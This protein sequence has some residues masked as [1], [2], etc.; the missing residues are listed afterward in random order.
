[1]EHAMVDVQED[2]SLED[3]P[4][5]G[6]R[7]YFRQLED[8]LTLKKIIG[9]YG[10]RSVGKSRFVKTFIHQQM[11]SFAKE[12]Y[13]SLDEVAYSSRPF[14]CQL[15]VVADLY[16][17]KDTHSLYAFMCSTLGV[18]PENDATS[19]NRWKMHIKEVLASNQRRRVFLVFDNAEDVVESNTMFEELM[20]L[21][22]ILVK[23]CRTVKIFITGTTL[24]NFARFGKIYYTL[25]LPPLTE[26]E[27]SQLLD[28]AAPGVQFG[29]EKKTLVDLSEGIPLLILMIG[30]ELT[31][32]SQLI[33]PGEMVE[34]L[35]KF[36]LE[37][38]S[39]DYYPPEQRAAV[40][41]RRF[42]FRL[43]DIYQSQFATLGFI[44]GSFDAHEAKQILGHQTEAVAK[45]ETLIP[46]RRRH[47]L[48]FDSCTGRF[49]IQGVLR[50][51]LKLYFKIRNLPEVRSRYYETFC[52]VM[53]RICTDLGTAEYTRA[54]ALF[55]LEQPN[56][57]KLL[58]EVPNSTQDNYHFF[59]EVVSSCSA[60]IERFMSGLSDHFYSQC[61]LLADRYGQELDKANVHIAMGSSATNSKGNFPDGENH[62]REALKVLKP[63]GPSLS[64]ATI[65]QRLGWN[66]HSQG[67]SDQSLKYLD[68][69]LDISTR[70]GP[71]YQQLLLQTLSSLGIVHTWIGSYEMAK[72][73][74]FEALR[75]RRIH[76]GDNHPF[77]GESL[78]NIGLLF[79]QMG[80]S[81]TA[82]MYF[83]Q[84][85]E[86][87]K[88]N[89]STPWSISFSLNNVANKYCSLNQFDKAL[90]LLDESMN[91]LNAM[92][93][94][95]TG[96]VSLT[97]NS[98]GKVYREMGMYERSAQMFKKAVDMRFEIMPYSI[99]YIWSA[100]QLAKVYAE[101]NKFPLCLWMIREILQ[102]K[103]SALKTMP[104]NDF[105]LE[106]LQMEKDV[107]KKTGKQDL[108]KDALWNIQSELMRLG[109]AYLKRGKAEKVQ[110]VTQKLKEL[111]LELEC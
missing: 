47:M 13:K 42:I 72:K 84:G 74:H 73:Y 55:S 61:L 39:K 46:I 26:T 5:V 35:T 92:D 41:Y 23:H 18:V 1:M 4:F 82:L 109:D 43:S 8:I 110:E 19:G 6:R 3:V 88:K 49:D 57:Y 99:A 20:S 59:L 15:S 22:T 94:P 7:P 86:I 30:A 83:E 93:V 107:Y 97:Y 66:L 52:L 81:E 38:L 101:L 10:L 14:D 64:L 105:V 102:R 67:C 58:T 90:D 9:V 51:C 31:E 53:K 33:T 89:K 103:E 40:V 27:A 91:I 71:D 76:L 111:R 54:L 44:P 32:D 45:L 36:R 108:Y 63:R 60:L 50:E 80:D 70:S 79:D 77:I 34:L 24:V 48:K 12:E 75:R 106:C 96:A 85:L 100:I 104:H 78:N 16:L 21:I 11:A 95:H 65:Y 2:G 17:H 68:K 29:L 87:K 25:E 62:Y 98:Y 28:F 37:A 56:L 69:S